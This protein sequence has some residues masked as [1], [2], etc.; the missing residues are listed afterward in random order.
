MTLNLFEHD[1]MVKAKL[2]MQRKMTPS[3]WRCC[4]GLLPILRLA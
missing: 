3:L 2:E 4:L 1:R